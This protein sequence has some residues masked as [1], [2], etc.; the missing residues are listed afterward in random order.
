MIEYFLVCQQNIYP[1]F[2]PAAEVNLNIYKKQ[3]VPQ[4]PTPRHPVLK[5][6]RTYGAF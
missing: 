1:L 4:E 5:I 3:Q 2:T 6:F